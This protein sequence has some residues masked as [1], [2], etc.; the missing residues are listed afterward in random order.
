M[1]IPSSLVEELSDQ[2]NWRLGTI[3][4]LCGHVQVI[5]EQNGP[6]NLGAVESFTFSVHL[7]VNDVLSLN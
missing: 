5:D 3:L 4:F 1:L 7:A 6:A 2:L